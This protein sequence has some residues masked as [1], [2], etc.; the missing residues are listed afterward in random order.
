MNQIA[1]QRLSGFVDYFYEQQ[2]QTN[3]LADAGIDYAH[4]VAKPFMKEPE[5]FNRHSYLGFSQL[6][7]ASMVYLALQKLGYYDR[8][9]QL[10]PKQRVRFAFG[11]WFEYTIIEML[12]HY[13]ETDIQQGGTLDTSGEY[14]TPFR[15][16]FDLCLDNAFMYDVKTMT[17][18][19]YKKFTKQP[20]NYLGYLTQLSLYK[21]YYDLAY[22]TDVFVGWICLNLDTF[23]VS[24]VEY[25]YEQ[26]RTTLKA[27]LEKMDNIER[28]K[29][30]GDV[31][32]YC[33]FPEARAEVFQKEPTGK[34]YIPN[35]IM[36]HRYASALFN[37]EVHEN[38]YGKPMHYFLNYK[39]KSQFQAKVT[40]LYKEA[41]S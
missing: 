22:N 4:N 10:T 24:V 34:H 19:S 9:P 37:T 30:L 6:G 8:I 3:P 14:E 1:S 17:S 12:K 38:G 18:E 41:Q 20:N 11:Y 7:T 13:G 40:E 39:S 21:H 15:G 23:H 31:Y 5:K 28:V 35:N 27:A 29:T 25:N 16:H 33:P 32:D 26:H 2:P 36:K